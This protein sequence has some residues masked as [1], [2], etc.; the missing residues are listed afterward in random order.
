[1]AFHAFISYST[2]DLTRARQVKRLLERTGCKT[3]LAD[4]SIQPGGTLEQEIIAAI[5]RCDVF[6]L[7]WSHHASASEW[8]SQEIG[9][10]KAKKKPIIPIMLHKSALPPG[11]LR[12][13]KYLPLYKNP[14]EGLKWLQDNV[15]MR[16][17]QKQKR[18]GLTWL[19]LGTVLV[20][21]LGNDEEPE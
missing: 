7:L 17:T 1:M 2:R 16:A 3:F 13:T 5:D 8:V 11:F 15:F 18:D 9:I 19:G 20:W 21:A 4:S 10:A 14:D 12:G 6:I